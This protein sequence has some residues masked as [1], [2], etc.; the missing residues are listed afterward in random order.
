MAQT[1]GNLWP[2]IISWPSLMAAWERTARGR[3]RQRDVITFRA[4]LEPNLIEIQDSLIHRTYRTGPY[5]RF[6]IYEPKKREIASLPLKD[7]VVQHALVAVVDP[8]FEARYID[9]SF[10]CRVGKGAHKGA[11]P[12]ELAD[13]C[14]DPGVSARHRPRQLASRALN[15][16]AFGGSTAQTTSARAHIEATTSPVWERRRRAIN[17][18]FFWQTDH[19]AASWENEV[20]RARYVLS[21]LEGG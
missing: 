3:T 11:V 10:A 15:A 2:E 9:Q 14:E 1:Y 8:I 7:R 13:Q 20:D 16:L 12:T 19:C 18:A 17:A 4:N 21:R 6:F 5:H